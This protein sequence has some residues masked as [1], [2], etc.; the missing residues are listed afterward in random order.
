MPKKS[1]EQKIRAS[2]RLFAS[3]QRASLPA[4]E[5]QKDTVVT[6][7]VFKTITQNDSVDEKEKLLTGY[8]LAD[9]RKSM[10]FISC[11]IALEIFF[12]FASMSTNL[13]WAFKL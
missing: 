1:R 13:A 6:T 7:Q 2:E 5:H 11:V 8:F 12:Y 3:L 9:F 4:T 10:I